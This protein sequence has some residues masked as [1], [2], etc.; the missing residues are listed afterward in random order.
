MHC[1]CDMLRFCGLVWWWPLF[2]WSMA[3]SQNPLFCL[4]FMIH[5][6]NV[7]L[8]LIGQLLSS[9]VMDFL[10]LSLRLIPC[11]VTVSIG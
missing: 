9:G 6:Y 4:F 10:N 5:A 1:K 7:I 2:L 11:K 3:S 8:C